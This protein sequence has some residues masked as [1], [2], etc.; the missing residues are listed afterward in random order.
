M[1]LWARIQSFFSTGL[2][3][4]VSKAEDPEKLIELLLVEM[5][6]NYRQG[7]ERLMACLAEEKRA[8]KRQEQEETAA[9]QYEEEATRALRDGE[10]DTAESAVER[11]CVH[12]LRGERH[13]AIKEIH[14]DNALALKAALEALSLQIKDARDERALLLAEKREASDRVGQERVL[15]QLENREPTETLNRLLGEAR[16]V[17][18]P[19]LGGEVASSSE[20]TPLE[21]TTEGVLPDVSVEEHVIYDELARLKS[22]LDEEEAP[23]SPQEG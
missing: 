14:H 6:S 12:A 19:A 9:H 5:E 23:D 4:L 16:A 20:E 2:H 18:L 8:E 13:A 21:S 3:A 15:K 22:L 11:K 1:A 17:R 7:R 10:I